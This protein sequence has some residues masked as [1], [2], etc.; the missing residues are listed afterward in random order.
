MRANNNS[1][2]NSSAEE[3]FKDNVKIENDE[4][5]VKPYC[6]FFICP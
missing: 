4:I 2:N 5:I 1:H 3:V 6:T